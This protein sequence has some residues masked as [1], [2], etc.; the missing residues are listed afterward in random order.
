M[1]LGT[2]QQRHSHL[3]GKSRELVAG[4]LVAAPA[5]PRRPSRTAVDLSGPPL[6]VGQALVNIAERYLA[7]QGLSQQHFP[8]VGGSLVGDL[9]QEMAEDDPELLI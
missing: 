5:R 3:S 9:F 2:G 8:G 6:T 4:K 1:S 7:Q